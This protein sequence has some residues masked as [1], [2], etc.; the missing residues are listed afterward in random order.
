M[1]ARRSRRLMA[2]RN[3]PRIRT[4]RLV[5]LV[6][7]VAALSL[8]AS[9]NAYVYWAND[10]LGTVT[11]IGRATL[12]GTGVNQSL[13]TNTSRA[14]GDWRSTASTSIGQTLSR[15][16]SVAPTSMAAAP[17]RLS[18][19][20]PIPDGVAVD[21]QHVYWAKERSEMIRR[22]N[23]DG[24]GVN[25]SFIMAGSSAYGVTVDGRHIYWAEFRGA[26][27]R[28]SLDGTAVDQSLISAASPW[29]RTWPSRG[30]SPAFCLPPK[31]VS[32]LRLIHLSC[33]MRHGNGEDALSLVGPLI[34]QTAATPLQRPHRLLLMGD[35]IVEGSGQ[36][37][38]PSA[39]IDAT[40]EP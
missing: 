14:K 32:S 36:R 26:I 37:I 11:T 34:S 2:M 19:R 39:T 33:R 12:D 5:L 40:A 20:A 27:G 22:A 30:S 7:T 17:T 38:A 15:A 4:I 31:D 24:T 13:I 23:L 16:R 18:S 28:A 1:I 6:F 35:Q 10:N 29:R 8:P 21:G 3:A 25:Q 9:A